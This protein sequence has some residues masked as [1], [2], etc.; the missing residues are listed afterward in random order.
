MNR[1][2]INRNSIGTILASLVLI[3]TPIS[4]VLAQNPNASIWIS[5]SEL[6]AIKMEGSSW[7]KLKSAAKSS[8]G[9][10]DLS[11]QDQDNNIKV[12]A[13]A[14]VY[15]RCS[16]E[17]LHSQCN[18]INLS[19]LYDEVVDQI[20]SAIGTEDG[21]RTL[22]LARE[23]VAYVIAADLVGMPAGKDATFRSWLADVR[24]EKLDGKTLISTHEKRANNWGTHAGASRAAASLY[25]GD[26]A[27]LDRI[28][29]VMKGWLGD[30]SSYAGFDY[31]NLSW[32]CDRSK[33]VGINPKECMRQDHSIDG[34]LPDDQRRGGNF[35]WPPPKENYVYEGL[36][37]AIVQAVILHRAGYNSFQWSD[38]ALLRAYRWL[39]EQAKFKP[40]GD[41]TWQIPLVDF[42]YG[43]DYWNGGTTN[44]GKNIGWTD[45]SHGNRVDTD[46]DLLAP[47]PPTI[48]S[49][50]LQMSQNY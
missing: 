50:D 49:I 29:Q 23:L 31:G 46:P 24:H 25:L 4:Q 22:A 11:D 40:K 14:L 8:A 27:D 12:L 5:P 45:W 38:R 32:Q 39:L 19:N 18:D 2:S 7:E 13:K 9:R 30:R 35:N 44:A 34:A 47:A 17:P 28:A 21:G 41:D 3:V 26:T 36:Q 16:L 48:I 43:T 6:A 42:Y 20:M 15:A 1:M 10:P 33:P 37:G